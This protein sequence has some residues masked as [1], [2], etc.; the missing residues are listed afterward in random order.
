MMGGRIWVESEIGAGS[1]F[2]FTFVAKAGANAPS[3]RPDWHSLHV[4][5]IDSDPYALSHFEVIAREYGF[6]CDIAETYE[7][8]LRTANKNEEYSFYFVTWK[9]QGVEDFQA[10]QTLKAIHPEAVAVLIVP[11]SLWSE[12]E[13]E[14]KKSGIDQ[15][16]HKPLFASDV[17]EIISKHIEA[18]SRLTD[19]AEDDAIDSFS[20]R[21]ILLAEDVEINRE[22]VQILLGELSIDIDCAKNG[23]EALEIFRAAP[24]RYDMILM[25]LQM[26]EMDGYESTRQI[27]SL[28]APNAKTIPIIAMTADVFQE[29]IIRCREAGMN[30]HISK[31]L[32][33]D[34]V[35]EKLRAYLPKASA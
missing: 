31:P 2:T 10:I 17:A 32:D 28:D 27:R 14:A 9:T 21:R 20:G 22:I 23:L 30:D 19:D 18:G 24:G 25:D 33:F 11:A 13:K 35:T 34:I 8:A 1:K 29:D 16:L 7:E 4:L 15:F 12:I 26:P 3:F 5:A 6:S